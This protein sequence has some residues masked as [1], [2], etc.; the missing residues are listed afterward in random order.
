MIVCRDKPPGQ[1]ERERKMLFFQCHG[2]RGLLESYESMM[3]EEAWCP[4]CG[5][6]NLVPPYSFSFIAGLIGQ[7]HDTLCACLHVT[8]R[9]MG[10]HLGKCYTFEAGSYLLFHLRL[11]GLEANLPEWLATNL[12]QLCRYK[13]T[14]EP[15]SFLPAIVETRLGAYEQSAKRYYA[16]ED[17]TGRE[18]ASRRM[19]RQYLQQCPD[20]Y[21]A[22]TPGGPQPPLVDDAADARWLDMLGD[23]HE[24]FHQ[25]AL[26]LVGELFRTQRQLPYL[27]PFDVRRIAE[28]LSHGARPSRDHAARLRLKSA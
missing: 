7:T 21:A 12:T 9:T 23:Y 24:A 15:Y 26:S 11:A 3:G 25:P 5:Q 18:Q 17:D 28:R 19:L 4:R 27:G 2:C 10:E 1:T 16:S 8:A 20:D 6:L 13:I 22:L 14:L